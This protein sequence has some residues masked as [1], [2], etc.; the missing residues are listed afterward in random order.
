MLK[1]PELI[2]NHKGRGQKVL[3][4]LLDE[5]SSCNYF[6]FSVAFITQSGVVCLLETLLRLEQKNIRGRILTSQYLNFTQPQALESLLKLSNVEVRIEVKESFHSK[7]YLFKS[8]NAEYS[9]YI[10]SS[11]LTSNALTTNVEL[12]IGLTNLSGEDRF[13]CD[14][15]NDFNDIWTNAQIVDVYFISEYKKV[16]EEARKRREELKI[17]TSI[18]S[19][20]GSP[21]YRKISPNSMQ[22]VALENLAKLRAEGENRALIISATGTGKTYL[23]AFDV[24]SVS[25][26]RVLFVVH[27]RTIAEKSMHTFKELM[28]NRK[29]GLYS[30]KDRSNADFLFATIQTIS[31]DIASGKFRSDFFDYVIID[32]THRAEAKSYNIIIDNLSPKFLLGMTATPERTDGGDVFKLFNHNVAYEIRLHQALEE[33]MLVPFHYFGVTDLTI[34]GAIVEDHSNFNLLVSDERVKHIVEKTRFYGSDT[35]IIRGLI[36]CS[37]LNECEELA[38]KL[39]AHGLKTQAL[40]GDSKESE[41]KNAIEDL[42]SG[43]LDYIITVDIFNEGV[44]IPSVNQVVMLRPTQ[45]AII[46]VQQLGRGL[47]KSRGKEY[48]TIIDFIGNYTNSYLIPIA[49]YGDSSFNKDNVRSLLVGGSQGLP[50]SCTIDFDEVSQKQIFDSLDQANLSKKKDLRDDYEMVMKIIGRVPFMMDF[51]RHGSRDPYLYADYA[52]SLYQFSKSIGIEMVEL[53]EFE[54]AVLSAY[55]RL[56]NDGKR[57]LDSFILFALTKESSISVR[58]LREEFSIKVGREVTEKEISDSIHCVNLNFD[59]TRFNKQDVSISE[60]LSLNLIRHGEGMVGRTIQFSNLLENLTFERYLV[61]SCLYSLHRFYAKLSASRGERNGFI[62]Y[63]KY[64]RRDVLRILGWDKNRN[65]STIGGY[66]MSPDKTNCPIFVTYHKG[67]DIDGSIAYEDEF[68]SPDRFKWMSR[69]KRKIDSAELEP[70]INSRAIGLRLPLFVKKDNNEGIDFYYLGE[71]TPIPGTVEQ[72][73]MPD[74]S[75]QNLPV[76][77]FEFD[78]TPPVEPSLYKYL[79]S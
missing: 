44:D 54:E 71:L 59:I 62:L 69:S 10:G 64:S 15:Q 51:I 28:P 56:I 31:K 40:T 61:D 50:G 23:S 2:V 8:T 12:N 18:V 20:S 24:L 29:M 79:I 78:I 41:R 67:E 34:D 13:I 49:L 76:V 26:H 74:D 11:N 48:L 68:L 72:Q 63:E 65:A 30:G 3:T 25:P 4:T 6:E 52:G 77:K 5:L 36:F 43:K 45:S 32:E 75:G 17:E 47:R 42:E 27:R 16:Y 33:D 35:G 57:F 7:G 9:L 1:P 14:Y 70:I 37:R 39:F 60:K 38:K 53:S 21:T 19:D 55:S 66:R 58:E 73:Y 46:F 22:T